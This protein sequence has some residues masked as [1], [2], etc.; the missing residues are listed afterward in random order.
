VR[1]ER[2][3]IDGIPGKL[4]MNSDALGLL[5]L[6]HGGGA[7]KDADRFV[8]LS[9]QYAERTGLAVVCIDAVD[10][11]E[12]KR[13]AVSPEIPRRWHSNAIDQMVNDWQR[14]V[15]AL[16][17][18]GPALAYVGFS[19]GAIFGVPIVAAMPS[20]TA[21]VFVVGGIPAGGGIDDPPLRTVLLD[22]ASRL[23]GAEVLM[24]NK[25]DDEIFP[26]EGTEALFKAI[27][28]NNKRLMFW[29]GIH[30]DWPPDLIRESVTFISQH[31]AR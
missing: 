20:I 30:D 12:R 11:G 7:S 9:R 31:A 24:L 22:A 19:M 15:A 26:V 29:E 27:P 3:E 10:H 25:R 18:I 6:G 17:S 21:A 13:A 14:T 1:E 5:L 2:V 4:Y 8:N 28:R 23:D 16:S